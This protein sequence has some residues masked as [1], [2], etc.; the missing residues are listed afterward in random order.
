LTISSTTRKAGPFIG[1]GVTIVFPFS[2]KVFAKGDV[3]LL[4]IDANGTETS[5]TLDSDYS[6]SI[7]ADQTNAPGGTIT[8]PISGSP[9]PSTNKLVALGD[10]PIEQQ[11]DITNSGGFYPQ[12]IEDMLD[13]AT[14]QIQQ[15]AE[16]V[17]RAIVVGASDT[18]TP[19]LPSSASRANTIL[20]FDSIGNLETMPIT[21]SVGA[22]D[23]RT[24]TFVGGVDYTAG[25]SNSV[26]L[27]RA[28]GSLANIEVFFDA[29]YQGPENFQSLVGTVLTFTAAIPVGI[30]RVYVRGGSTLS[31]YSPST[32]SVFDASVAGGSRLFNRIN[33]RSS[34]KDAPFNA[35]GDG[36]S[37]D[38]IAFQA[39]C[40]STVTGQV[41][42]V[43]VPAGTYNLFT[44]V[45]AG[46][47]AVNWH[48]AAGASLSGSGKLAHHAAAMSYNASPNVGKRLSIWHGT[49]A[50]PTTDG[51]TST[52]YIQRVD[53]SHV[54]DDPGHLMSAL[55]VTH[56]RLTGGS[57]WL[58]GIY[59][60]LEDQSNTTQAQSVA[61]AGSFHGTI[62]GAGWGL[63]GEANSHSQFST[64]QGGEFDC[65]NFTGVDYAY[66]HLSPLTSG[67]FSMGVWSFS[68][69]GKKNTIAYGVG[70]QNTT[71][72]VA[73]SWHVGMYL[74]P[75]SVID[76]GI[77][78]QAQ[79]KVLINFEN[80]ASTDGTGLVSG[81]I[82][83]DVGANS[84]YGTGVNQ[85]AIHLRNQRLG[86][87][88]FGF[89]QFN[90]GSNFLEF[91]S[92]TST[93][94]AHIDLAAGTFNA[95]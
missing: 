11:T 77:D 48:F 64:I 84:A 38:T 66:N 80:G 91:W 88:S 8:Y 54:P 1:N 21:A 75:W 81:G 30:Q 46:A 28:P 73:S 35:V 90:A 50:N 9:L 67:P 25:V 26:T 32:G 94:A 27:S 40:N 95:G 36:V 14:I 16:T 61:V 92:S 70:A 71:Q 22:G 89:I 63:Y 49:D 44:N 74:S 10:L 85:C 20:G 78:I 68:G 12:I 2:F 18:S 82:G 55:Y 56:K 13:R 41:L 62:S 87:G 23:L 34:A 69:G 6:V 39:I 5:L 60:Y 17:S 3:A 79:P 33:Y 7:N 42:D 59:G 58:Y 24:D 72:S 51:V 65:F 52:A 31:I 93:R 37:N 43:D 53:Q 15:V 86:F 76:Y 83:L 19:A 29:A 45:T 4:L 57:G 47:G